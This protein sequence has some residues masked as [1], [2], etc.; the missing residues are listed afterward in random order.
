MKV[1]SVVFLAFLPALPAMA[2]QN[3]PARKAVKNLSDVDKLTV[4][5]SAGKEVHP[6]AGGRETEIFQHQGHGCLTH[7]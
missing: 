2:L 5:G 6:F 4:F 3:A 1:F 7:M